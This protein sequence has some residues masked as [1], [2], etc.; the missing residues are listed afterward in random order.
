MQVCMLI[1]APFVT[2]P[3]WKF[4][5]CLSNGVDELYYHHTIGYYCVTTMKD[6]QS[7]ATI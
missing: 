6:P 3:N 4:L 1:I 2:A 5:T 7:N